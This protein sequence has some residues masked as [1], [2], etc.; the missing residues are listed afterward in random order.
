MKF[1]IKHECGGRMR[2]QAAQVRMTL[3]QAD[4][5]EAWLQGLPQVERLCS[6]AHPL[7]R[8]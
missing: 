6:R 2:V 4:M 1:A 8:D 7:R 3:E 5:L